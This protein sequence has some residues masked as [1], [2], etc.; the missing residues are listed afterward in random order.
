MEYLFEIPRP[1]SRFEELRKQLIKKK[2]NMFGLSLVFVSTLPLQ[3]TFDGG[4]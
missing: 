4:V 2:P 1:E 3:C